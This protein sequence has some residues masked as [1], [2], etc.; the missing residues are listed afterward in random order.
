MVPLGECEI[1][2]RDIWNTNTKA[3]NITL[4]RDPIWLYL[5]VQS[6][7][8]SACDQ[9]AL[10][11]VWVEFSD[12]LISLPLPELTVSNN[13]DKEK[14]SIR[15]ANYRRV[16]DTSTASISPM[17]TLLSSS[18]TQ[19]VEYAPSPLDRDESLKMESI[20]AQHSFSNSS[21]PTKE[22]SLSV[23]IPPCSDLDILD[24]STETASPAFNT[25][26]IDIL[27]ARVSPSAKIKRTTPSPSLQTKT[28]VESTVS[29]LQKEIKGVLIVTTGRGLSRKSG[30]VVN[31]DSSKDW[32]P[33]VEK[34]ARR[35]IRDGI[36]KKGK[37]EEDQK[38]EDELVQ[39]AME[40]IQRHAKGGLID[41]IGALFNEQDTLDDVDEKI[42]KKTEPCVYVELAQQ[43]V[44]LD[45]LDHRE[46][47][48][49]QY[50]VEIEIID[51]AIAVRLYVRDRLSLSLSLTH[52]HTHTK[53][54]NPTNNQN[55]TD[56]FYCV[57]FIEKNT[58]T[59]TREHVKR[60]LEEYE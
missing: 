18:T 59:S 14:T 35:A 23:G 2:L 9:N 10:E 57:G 13:T 50:A 53:K 17:K 52:T 30:A 7:L 24:P 32:L 38:E 44:G 49:M 51:G 12:T 41:E 11:D 37:E 16:I 48:W 20:K 22:K 5:R 54:K 42:I 46:T 4:R 33:R 21:L 8:S 56:T 60:R 36:Q 45:D 29:S 26:D 58:G 15:W 19:T 3:V 34:V 39:W 6:A 31:L 55:Y 25:S 1:P 28:S 40:V 47:P 43:I 27:P